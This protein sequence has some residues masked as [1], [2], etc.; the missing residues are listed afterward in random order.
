M[1]GLFKKKAPV[2]VTTVVEGTVKALETVSDP[3]FAQ[4]IAGRGI[5]V[6]PEGG[7]FYAPCDGV[8]TAVFPT[9]HA[10]G[11]QDEHGIEY[12][13]HI[14]INT[15][16]L[17]GEGFTPVVSQGQKVKKGDK[18]VDVDLE[19]LKAHDI[20]SDTMILVSTAEEDCALTLTKRDGDKVKVGDVIFTCHKK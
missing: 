20:S 18:L 12:L 13:I 8:L 10:Y 3:V 17:K 9:G 4:G 2:E 11:I 1:F 14:G 16:T 7:T 19:V 15:V 6:V 5:A